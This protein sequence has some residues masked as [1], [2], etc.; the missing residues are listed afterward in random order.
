MTQ[1]KE[2][3][4]GNLELDL[5]PNPLVTWPQDRCPWNEAEGTDAHRCA[6]KNTSMCKYFEGIKKLDIVLCSYPEGGGKA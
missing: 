5:L 4:G 2:L 6:V 1:I 3:K